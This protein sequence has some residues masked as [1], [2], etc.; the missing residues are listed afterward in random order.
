MRWGEDF[1]TLRWAED[2]IRDK[3]MP[4]DLRAA[5]LLERSNDRIVAE[6]LG[7]D[8]EVDAFSDFE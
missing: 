7:P 1:R 3:F 4:N 5:E 2:V 6:K 8:N